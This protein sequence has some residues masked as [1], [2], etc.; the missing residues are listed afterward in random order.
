MAQNSA[1]ALPTTTDKAHWVKRMD[2]HEI[3]Q[4]FLIE[5]NQ[6]LSRVEQEILA[7]EE[8]PGEQQILSS[9]FRTFHTVKGTCGFLGF[10]KLEEL[11]HQAENLL[12]E[13]RDG[14]RGF[15]PALASLILESV[16]AVNVELSAI[17]ATG[18]ESEY[19][20]QDLMG[21]LRG[22]PVAGP[23][24]VR[25]SAGPVDPPPSTGV[26]DTTIRVDTRLIDRLINMVGELVL[27]RNQV[28][29]TGTQRQGGDD[30]AIAHR[31]N[32]ITTE[33]QEGIMRSRMQPIGTIWNK[34]PR[35]VR[36]TASLLGKD[37]CLHTS[38]A[39]KE[40][41]RTILEAIKDPLTHILRNSCDH[42][43][44]LPGD[45]VAANKPPQGNVWVRAYHDGSQVILE[46]EDDGR[47]IDPAKLRAKAVE[48][49]L[50]AA[51]A[52]AALSD[53]EAIHLVFHPGF[54]T[55]EKVTNISGRGVGM[56]VVR[57][58]IQSIG[59]QVEIN[60][61]VGAGTQVRIRIPLTLAIIPGLII[62]S[63]G[64]TFVIP[65]AHLVEL[66]RLP[67]EAK[68]EAPDDGS[69]TVLRWRDRLL[70][71][72]ELRRA[73]RLGGTTS[74]GGESSNIA[75]LETEG[76]VFGLVVDRVRS[77]REIVVKP[78]GRQL[79]RLDWYAGATI[80]GD[81]SV[82]LILDVP[83]LARREKMAARSDAAKSAVE[84]TATTE[85]RQQFLL[86]QAGSYSRL[87]IP[88]A[89]VD[90]LEKFPASRLERTAESY[91]VQY[92]GDLL[93]ISPLAAILGSGGEECLQRPEFSVVVVRRGDAV[94]GLAVDR[95]I[96][97]QSGVIEAPRSTTA[98]G[99]LATFVLNGAA[100][101][102]V[103]LPRI[104]NQADPRCTGGRMPDRRQVGTLVLRTQSRFLAASMR[105]Y[106]ELGGYA[107]QVCES[108][109]ETVAALQ[110]K[111]RPGAVLVDWEEEPD[112][113]WLASL[114]QLSR[115]VSV[116][117]YAVGRP[118]RTAPPAWTSGIC[119]PDDFQS[120]LTLLGGEN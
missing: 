94:I 47:G 55:A 72:V 25:E 34:L 6:N 74:R 2:D 3:I 80:L 31:L 61:R 108:G 119:A 120:L 16:D 20:H 99:L 30:K 38:G 1:H 64:Q 52:A 59:G 118:D 96:D 90:R 83:G 115:A 82:A 100:T 98:E 70:P 13:V 92:R 58:N 17:E 32:L 114:E 51:P 46:I 14:K 35:L 81:G 101:D 28:L 57:Q 87:A 5:S 105:Q 62:S 11:T 40:M 36:D 43:L 68:G 9:I 49:G 45:R 60:S 26:T 117:V 7:L 97:V 53:R 103:D 86:F 23:E 71:L 75:I 102:M 106:L 50:L 116:P 85:A 77:T 42:G 41:D 44:E 39:D 111:A 54:S 15:T 67:T 109:D 4:D 113:G 79:K 12:G 69:G 19:F 107:L 66:L 21:K 24:T 8:R 63:G 65:Q 27:V 104:L 84:D 22:A 56:D 37:I 18:K 91:V 89:L 29:Q 95:V 48:K 76:T 73:L 33:L 88:L 10:P 78:L 112:A 110:G 93:P